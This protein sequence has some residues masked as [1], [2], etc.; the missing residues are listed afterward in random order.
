LAS[1][2]SPS[3]SPFCVSRYPLS[4]VVVR[5]GTF[6]SP[7]SSISFISPNCFSLYRLQF[8]SPSVSVTPDTASTHFSGFAS[9][10]F[11]VRRHAVY[12]TTTAGRCYVETVTPV[13][14]YV[15]PFGYYAS[16]SDTLVEENGIDRCV[17]SDSTG[18][19]TYYF[20]R[21]CGSINSRRYIRTERLEKD[22]VCTGCAVT[23]RFFLR[24]RY[25]YTKQNLEEFRREYEELPIYRKPLENK[26]LVFG[27]ALGLFVLFGWL[28]TN[29]GL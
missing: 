15:Y 10:R 18:S 19:S 12:L 23:E 14:E 11:S 3:S 8:P 7:T 22:R 5:I 1:T 13:K 4:S 9:I 21:N 27:I 25:F 6:L 17:H 28:L 26:P 24:K 2:I 20:C 29:S 16:G